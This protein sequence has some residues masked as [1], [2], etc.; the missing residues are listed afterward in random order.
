MYTVVGTMHN[1]NLIDGCIIDR[2]IR[3]MLCP[4]GVNFLHGRARSFRVFPTCLSPR[5]YYN[6]LSMGFCSLFFTCS[7]STI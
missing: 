3:G 7:I 1:A 4:R 2:I 6:I 5:W